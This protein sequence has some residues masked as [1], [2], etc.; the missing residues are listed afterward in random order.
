METRD[1]MELPED[2]IRAHYPQ[3]LALL[4]GFDHAPRLASAAP[5]AQ[6]DLSPGIPRASSRFRST[7]PG[8]AGLSTQRPGA[9]RLIERIERVGGDDLPSPLSATVIRALRR[10]AACMRPS[11]G[12]S[13]RARSRKRARA[14]SATAGPRR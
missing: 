4:T 3:A 12:S 8:L 6:G 7:T 10:A 13:S 1:E 2:R 11:S 5:A 14:P 9:V